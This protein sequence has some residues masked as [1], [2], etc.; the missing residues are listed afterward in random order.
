MRH[1][2]FFFR[3]GVSVNVTS[4]TGE[5]LEMTSESGATCLCAMPLE[6]V[7]VV[8]MEHESLPTGT[9]M[10]SAGQKLRPTSSTVS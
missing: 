8:C 5:K 10:P 6:S 7:H 1:D 3:S 9:E 4:F 2:D